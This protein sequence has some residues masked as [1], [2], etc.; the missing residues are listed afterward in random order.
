MLITLVRDSVLQCFCH[1]CRVPVM[2]AGSKYF[3]FYSLSND[4]NDSF[5]HAII[6]KVFG[7]IASRHRRRLSDTA[8]LRFFPF[9]KS[10]F[11]TFFLYSWTTLCKLLFFYLTTKMCLLNT[12]EV[13]TFPLPADDSFHHTIIVIDFSF[14]KKLILLSKHT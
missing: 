11:H 4:H 12:G 5:I 3:L 6:V 14:F 10:G 1:T 13:M 8:L 2:P 9:I 7:I